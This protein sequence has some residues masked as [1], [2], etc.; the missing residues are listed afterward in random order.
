MQQRGVQVVMMLAISQGKTARQPRGADPG[1]WSLEVGCEEMVIPGRASGG[2]SDGGGGGRGGGE[3][4]GFE[5]VNS[6][7]YQGCNNEFVG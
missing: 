6:R 5:R 3:D 1:A 2:G 7:R 4:G